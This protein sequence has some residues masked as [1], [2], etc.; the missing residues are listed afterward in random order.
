MLYAAN[1]GFALRRKARD[2]KRRAA[3]QIG[4]ENLIPL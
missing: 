1:H 3:P 4:G 2:Y